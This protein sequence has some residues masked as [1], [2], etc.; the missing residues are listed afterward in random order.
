M[1]RGSSNDLNSTNVLFNLSRKTRK[2]EA[3]EIPPTE[4]TPEGTKVWKNKEGKIHR[5]F[6]LPAIIDKN[7][8]KAWYQ[9]GNPHRDGDRPAVIAAN[10]IEKAWYKNG[11]LHRDD[12]KPAIISKGA[13]R[14]YKRGLSH[15]DNHFP[16]IEHADGQREW[17]VEGKRH[18]EIG[19]AV[20]H[21]QGAVYYFLNGEE[22]DPFSSPLVSGFE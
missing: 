12:D 7:G 14:W 18:C 11:D 8:K 10:G 3:A 15:R 6:D 2:E 22:V 5:D 20:I 4:I 1:G 21:P 9:N 16:A 19:P 13:R 17:W